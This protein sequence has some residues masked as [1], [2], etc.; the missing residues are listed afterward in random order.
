MK[1]LNWKTTLFGAIGGLMVGLQPLLEAYKSGAFD[2]KTG[3]QLAAAV[4]IVLL[5]VYSKDHDNTAK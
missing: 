4:A 5:G 2:G 1:L 3:S